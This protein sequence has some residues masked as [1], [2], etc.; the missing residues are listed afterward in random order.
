MSK[1][2]WIITFFLLTFFSGF[3][4]ILKK[5][6][7]ALQGSSHFVYANNKSYFL[8]ESIGQA[9]VIRTFNTNN[10]SLRQGFLQP[11]SATVISDHL[12]T[13][14]QGY[15]YPNPFEDRVYVRFDE[16]VYDVISVTMHDILGR[17]VYSKSFNPIQ[18][19]TI[20]FGD[21]SSGGYLLH[22][23]MRTEVLIAKLIRK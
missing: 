8:Q 13:N 20:N 16:P 7:L 12:D 6:T 2:N 18:T 11:I 14:L 1:Q 10:Y 9:S 4:Q 23:Q 3:G 17:L 5:E 21:L 19:L 15:F 22:I